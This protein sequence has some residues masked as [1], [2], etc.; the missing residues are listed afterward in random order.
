MPR[1]HE[2]KIEMVPISQI[3]VINPRA[4]NRRLHREIIENIEV[5]GL[6][7]PIT[8]SRR[9]G[10]IPARYDTVCGEGRLE[11][12]RILGARE[13]PAVVT[14]ASKSDCPQ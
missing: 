6:K 2:Q 1:S 13:I 8:V 11:A 5:I 12:F 3:T 14:E 10:E 7:R 9:Q 4:R